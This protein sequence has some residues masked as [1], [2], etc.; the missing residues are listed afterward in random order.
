MKRVLRAVLPKR[1]GSQL[2]VLVVVAVLVLHAVVSVLFYIDRLHRAA[3]GP[4]EV[5]GRISTIAA[6]L[7]ATPASA[8]EAQLARWRGLYPQLALHLDA[9][10]APRP[11]ARE[12][13]GNFHLARALPPPLALLE[14]PAILAGKD[15]RYERA[16]AIRLGDGEVLLGAMPVSQGPPQGVFWATL[17]FLAISITMLGVWSSYVVTAPLRELARAAETYNID[18]SPVALSEKGPREIRGA[19]IALNRMQHRISRLVTD[20]TRMLAAVSH[21]LRTP[22]TRLRLRSEFI[23][24]EQLRGFMLADLE[25]M[26]VL[27]DNALSYLRGGRSG[28]SET[29]TDLA[30]LMQTISDRFSDLGL[31][32]PL[33]GAPRLVASIRPREIE[34]AVTNLIENALRYA[35]QARLE[36]SRDEAGRLAFIDVID[37]G[38]GLLDADKT[39]LLDAF[40]RGDPA[41]MMDQGGLGLGLTIA[42]SIAEGHGGRLVLMDSRPHGLTARIEIACMPPAEHGV[43]HAA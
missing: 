22:L 7:D 11:A 19:A 33:A 32:V 43:A 3:N 28:E 8:R 20:R 25:H 35:G 15:G 6:S 26:N 42:R 4:A 2:A 24:D 34:Q 40:N 21:D 16:F 10:S 30:S 12:D 36:L 37:E 18:G 13:S 29:P 39:T 41:R 9:A 38:P 17:L 14:P 31:D 23:P 1:I 5:T 27:V